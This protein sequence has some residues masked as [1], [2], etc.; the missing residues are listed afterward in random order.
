MTRITSPRARLAAFVLLVGL[1]EAAVTV[2]AA[3]WPDLYPPAAAAGLAVVVAITAVGLLAVRFRRRT[4]ERGAVAAE[5]DAVLTAA[6][7][8]IVGVDLN[9]VI[10]SWSAGAEA[11]YG[12]N[13]EE[14]VGQPLSSLWIAERED[15]GVQDVLKAIQRGEPVRDHAAVHRSKDETEL[16]VSLATA[17]IL[18]EAGEVAGAIL[19]TT[20]VSDRLRAWARVSELEAKHRALMEGLPVV[21]YF[22]AV[23]DRA[24]MIDVGPGVQ[25]LL[26][27]STEELLSHPDLFSRLLHPDDREQVIRETAAARS[28]GEPF[29]SE[30]R[31]LLRG[32]GVVWVRD[33]AFTVR[34][35]H[36]EPLFVQGHLTDVGERR[37]A[38]EQRERLLTAERVAT[39]ESLSRQ[40][41]LD[42]LAR[43]AAILASSPEFETTI[44]RVAE[45]AVRDIA[46]WCVV[47][48]IEEDGSATRLAVA[49]GEPAP[50]TPEP[51]SHPEPEVLQVIRSG[52]AQLTA[53]RIRV[54]LLTRGR[55]IGALTLITAA[56]GRAYGAD[57]LALVQ[58][59]AEAAALAVEN[60]RLQREVEERADAARVLAYVGDGVMLVDRGGVIRL[61]NPAAEA[62]T[63]FAAA[64]LLNHAA[65]D[66]IPGWHAVVERTPVVDSPEPV[67]AET[68]PLETARGE[69]WISI[70]GV[71][72]FDGT[73][74]AFRDVTDDHRLHEL[75]ADFVATASH[76][77]RTPLAAVYG[78]AQTLRRHD[79][80]LDEAGR[81]RFVS[82]IVD[83]SDRLGRIVNEI[84]L[85][86]QLD[87]DRVDLT[88][89][90]F[91]ARDLLERVA[92]SIRTHAPP[93]IAIEVVAPDSMRPIAAD[94]D[95]V[96]QV[97]V[98]LVEN[99]IKY[100][101]DG[102]TVEIGVEAIDS[103]VRFHVRDEGMGIP[104]DEQA[105]IFEKF[106]RLDP[107][108]TRGV[109]GTGLGLYIC[110]ELVERMG[111]RIWVQSTS[112][113]GS[114]FF[115][116]LPATEPSSARVL[117]PETA[118]PTTSTQ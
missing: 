116:E 87:A 112:G 67:H 71:E 66:A 3:V 90:P 9:G 80:A 22:R 117:A 11:L 36:G 53:S 56:P 113:G 10:I 13:A 102:G 18:G 46:D 50:Q 62:I 51:G 33:E 100:S 91:D 40:R 109:G 89:E 73:V 35:A 21:P 79:F 110:N 64:S 84:L 78:A 68:L 97:L 8:A 96:R 6:S 74:Y 75:K 103:Q 52:R 85:A 65:G 49:R 27:Y 25:E 118:T 99:A 69:R 94:R 12:F 114:T 19:A 39:A 108:M 81:E 16:S 82:L 54:P 32:G 106:Y 31:M 29:R 95:R 72:F 101:P 70:S 43:A 55:A 30:Y 4:L 5:L 86:S 28:R 48:L 34:D 42:F 111:G 58:N 77:L 59:L 15:P 115:F 60:G 24:A 93:G 38:A 37:R 14:A 107:A 92:E 76:E 45:L 17:P 61:W 63:G 98:N 20:D 57:D 44:R 26:G 23:G 41:K 7:E 105:R 88:S 1:L 104:D 83:E 2:P 47:D